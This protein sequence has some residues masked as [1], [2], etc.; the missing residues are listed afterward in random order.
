MVFIPFISWFYVIKVINILNIWEV[1]N[2][3]KKLLVYTISR[4]N[5][6]RFFLAMSESDKC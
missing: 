2:N 5:T 4:L 6:S 3:L 1:K